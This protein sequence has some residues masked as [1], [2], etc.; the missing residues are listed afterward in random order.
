MTDAMTEWLSAAKCLPD[1]YQRAELIGRVWRP[2]V[3]GPTLVRVDGANVYDLSAV[4]ATASQL[5][6]LDDPV[7]SIRRAGPL[8]KI[9]P[10]V[11]IL[12]S[13]APDVRRLDT[14]WLLAPCDLQ[15]I[16][17]SGVTF[18][19]SLLERV[20]EEQ[21]RGDAGKAEAACARRSP[22]SSARTC[23][24]SARALTRRAGSK[25]SSSARAYGPNI[26]RS[27]SART[28]RFSPRV[29]RCPQWAPART[30]ASIR[31][32]SGTTRSRRSCWR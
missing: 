29:S 28:R 1:D 19:A 8:P 27:A 31:N 22:R 20:I 32:R 30:S 15:A 16:K 4:A 5:L 25:R 7:A 10:L 24:R 18:V 23:T 6:N 13:S 3:Q 26:S 9:A 2:D 12:A 21:A 11:D 14:P 17:A